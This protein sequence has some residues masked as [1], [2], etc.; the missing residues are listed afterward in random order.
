MRTAAIVPVKRF[1][2]AKQRLGASVADPLRQQLARAMVADVLAALVRT[3]S[4]HCII[5]VTGEDSVAS[6]ARE[7]GLVVLADGAERGQSAAVARGIGAALARGAERAL[8]VPGDCP[9]L[10]P[11]ELE[12][13]LDPGAGAQR[14]E[15]V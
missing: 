7:Q 1:A 15:V 6:A 12:V 11:A 4:I 9:A 13:L 10:D 2:F 8:C 5:V 14:P 3:P